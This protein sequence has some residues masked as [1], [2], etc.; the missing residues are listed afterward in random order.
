MLGGQERADS[1]DL[2]LLHELVRS[3]VDPIRAS[4]SRRCI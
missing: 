2:E 1:A 3:G 4:V